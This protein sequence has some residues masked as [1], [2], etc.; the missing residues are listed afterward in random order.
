MEQT[1]LKWLEHFDQNES[2]GNAATK[3]IVEFSGR[4]NCDWLRSVLDTALV[5]AQ[6]EIKE[7]LQ[8]ATNK[9]SPKSGRSHQRCI[10]SLNG[11]RGYHKKCS[12]CYPRYA[13]F[14]A[15]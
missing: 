3:Y 13:N 9:Q 4:I 10:Y 5:K 7:D 2:N 6:Q 12:T 1:V 15:A 11:K 14:K 8:T